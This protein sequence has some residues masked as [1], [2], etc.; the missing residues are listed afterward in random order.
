[1][2]EWKPTSLVLSSAVFLSPSD[3][4]AL[5]KA[6]SLSSFSICIF[7]LMASMAAYCPGG[8]QKEE[9]WRGGEERLHR[10]ELWPGVRARGLR[11]L[12]NMCFGLTS[13]EGHLIPPLSATPTGWC[14]ASLLFLRSSSAIRC[15]DIWPSIWLNLGLTAQDIPS[16][17]RHLAPTFYP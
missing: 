6:F 13:S 16:G 15:A 1:M 10:T 11:Q 5:S 4:S 7:F 8:W 17:P 12:T 9:N 14:R 2:P 3:C